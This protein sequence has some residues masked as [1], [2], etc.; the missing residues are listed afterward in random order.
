[1]K[2]EYGIVSNQSCL[3]KITG[4]SSFGFLVLKLNFAVLIVMIYDA[5][6]E[7]HSHFIKSKLDIHK[8]I[9]EVLSINL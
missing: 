1:M 9:G 8:T 7:L 3:V 2:F 4:L 6:L 5:F